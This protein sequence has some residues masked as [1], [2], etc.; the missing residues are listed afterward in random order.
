MAADT[1]SLQMRHTEGDNMITRGAIRIIARG[2]RDC[3]CSLGT[4]E[5]A[6]T[7]PRCPVLQIQ[8]IASIS[9]TI[10]VFGG[11]GDCRARCLRSGEPAARESTKPRTGLP[12]P[13]R[14]AGRTRSCQRG[15]GGGKGRR[16]RESP[17]TR[18]IGGGQTVDRDRKRGGQRDLSSKKL[19]LPQA[20]GRSSKSSG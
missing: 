12:S 10:G 6:R 13:A 1:R 17:T 3:E 20:L 9:E 7:L 4:P 11:V 2:E 18:G 16:E 15:K 19:E 8:T 14:R 5:R